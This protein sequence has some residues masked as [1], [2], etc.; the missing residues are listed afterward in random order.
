MIVI[1]LKVISFTFPRFL[2]NR[3]GQIM[4]FIKSGGIF[5]CENGV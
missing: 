5:M 4:Y 2:R 1:H 3:A